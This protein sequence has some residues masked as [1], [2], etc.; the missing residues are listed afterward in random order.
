MG[1]DRKRKAVLLSFLSFLSFLSLCGESLSVERIQRQGPAAVRIE[2][3]KEGKDGL[4]MRLSDQLPLTLTVEGP[5]L[6]DGSVTLLG[7][8]AD[9]E[10]QAG[11]PETETL[12]AGRKRW[13]QRFQL[14]P[15]KPGALLLEPLPLRLGEQ[16]ITWTPVAVVVSTEVTKADVQELRDV[17]PPE[18][19][20]PPPPWWPWWLPW[21]ALGLGV[22]VL[23]L[24]GWLLGRRLF[25]D[26]VIPA[27]PAEWALSELERL[28]QRDLPAAGQGQRYHALL[29]NLVRRYVERRFGL[30]APRQTTAEFLR[31]LQALPELQSAT[32]ELL[33]DL[34][35]RCDLV[36][37]AGVVP[38]ADDCRAAAALAR[39]FVQATAVV[40]PREEKKA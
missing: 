8:S 25:I 40:T 7:R 24:G 22:T 6:P 26:Q 10:V 14:S 1:A 18:P 20:P 33:G 16:E 17:L 29:S 5:E 2:A 31:G 13:R 9:W 34:L 19:V 32:R 23:G 27:T 35:A 21:A 30:H 37:F 38:S 12:A 11:Q 15:R 28:E 4:E 3:E 36:K 39:E